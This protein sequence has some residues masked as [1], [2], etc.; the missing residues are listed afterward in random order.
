MI[1]TILTPNQTLRAFR[2][3]DAAALHR[4]LN[5]ENILQYYPNPQ[6]PPLDRVLNF[7]DR[8]L[9]HWAEHGYG[10]W[11][12]VPFGSQEPI[13]WNGLQYLPETGETEV[14]FLLSRA[15]W[16][17]GLATEGAQAALHFGFER[18]GLPRIIGLV[19]K[20]NYASQRVL[21]KV[22]MTFIDQAQYFGME[23]L[24]YARDNVKSKE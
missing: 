11:A 23:L 24:R 1:P 19:H 3:E 21:E 5:E 17:R 6:P 15:Y 7:I 2:K 16:N 9:A 13:G 22:G 18:F 20:E 8:Q 12:V 4:V 14:G 10:W